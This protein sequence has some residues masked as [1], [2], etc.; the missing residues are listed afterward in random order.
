MQ[1]NDK[2]QFIERL[3][4]TAGAC[5]KQKPKPVAFL[6]DVKDLL[7]FLWNCDEYDYKHPRQFNQLSFSVILM[8]N[9][10]LRPGEV[11]ESSQ[12]RASGEGITYGDVDF[13]LTRKD[14]RLIYVLT[15]CLRFRKNHRNRESEA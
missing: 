15:I 2:L 3:G 9:Y 13:S 4:S 1:R 12:H 8:A 10:G 11:V 14:G 7:F 6:V 5:Q